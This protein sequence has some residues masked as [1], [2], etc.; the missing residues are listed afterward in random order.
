MHGC[1]GQDH[2]AWWVLLVQV[3]QN[4]H[5]VFFAPGAGQQPASVSGHQ[6]RGAGGGGLVFALKFAGVA[7]LRLSGLGIKDDDQ[8]AGMSGCRGAAVWRGQ[9]PLHS[10]TRELVAM[11]LKA[12]RIGRAQDV[13]VCIAKQY[14]A[15]QHVVLQCARASDVCCHSVM[16]ALGPTRCVAVMPTLHG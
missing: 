5:I 7:V 16:L 15:K 13:A 11:R 6:T 3:Q 1:W 10:R 12:R 14:V 4:A 8:A 2:P 9:Q